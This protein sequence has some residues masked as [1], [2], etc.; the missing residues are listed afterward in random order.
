ML[1]SYL[2]A[3]SLERARYGLRIELAGIL[4]GILPVTIEVVFRIIMP[5]LVL[6]GADF[7]YLTV[8]LIPVALVMAIMR[9]R[10]AMEFVDGA[11]NNS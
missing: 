8:V 9:Q 7:Y 10:S 11:F 6:P 2:K 4:L 3:T 1:H 5:R